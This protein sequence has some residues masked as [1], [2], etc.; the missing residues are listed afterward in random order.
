LLN[1]SDLIREYAENALAAEKA[2]E[3][4]LRAFANEGDDDEVQLAFAQQ[5]NDTRLQIGRLQ[6]HLAAPPRSSDAKSAVAAFLDAAPTLAQAGDAV[7]ERLVQNLIAAY[8]VTAGQCALYEALANVAEAVGDSATGAL[9]REI[10]AEK[11][12][13]G[14]KL[15]HFLPTRSKIAYNVLTRDEIDPSV[16]TKVGIT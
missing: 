13:A 7:E 3:E 12:R 5:A 11:Q 9:A 4:R 10:Q 8:C 6:A 16:E 14:E 2:F 15:F 1:S